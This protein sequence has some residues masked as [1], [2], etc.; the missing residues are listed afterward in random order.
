MRRIANSQS[1]QSIYNSKCSKRKD[2]FVKFVNHDN[3]SKCKRHL[4]QV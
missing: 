4:S 1:N 2:N 3:K